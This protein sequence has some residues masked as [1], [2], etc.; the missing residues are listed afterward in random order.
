VWL[1]ALVLVLS[2]IP[3]V[4]ASAAGFVDTGG[5][6][7]KADIDWLAAQGITKGC[8]PPT[9]DKFCPSSQV[10]RGQMA[11]F[12][13]RALKVPAAKKDYFTD[14]AGSVFENDI[15][16]LAASGITKGCNPPTNNKFARTAR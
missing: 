2:V 1:I 6:V 14:D 15:N 12:L 11:A 10:T 13:T 5:S 4:G 16:R 8:N 7:F 3:L 9:N